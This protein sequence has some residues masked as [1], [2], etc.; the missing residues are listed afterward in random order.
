MQKK[1][2]E[3]KFN[4]AIGRWMLR[5]AGIIL[6]VNVLCRVA[7]AARSME[8][9]QVSGTVTKTQTTDELHAGKRS[10]TYHVWATYPI[11]GMDWSQYISEDYSFDMFSTGDNVSVLY[12]KDD[13]F[14]AY[15]AKK[16]WMTGAYLPVS[17]SYNIPL[18]ISIV[19]MVVGSL[20]Y[21]NS[22]VL[23]W[24]TCA[25]ELIIGKKRAVEK[26]EIWSY[27]QRGWITG[28]IAMIVEGV[29]VLLVFF[30]CLLNSLNGGDYLS[31][32]VLFVVS[33]SFLVPGILIVKWAKRC[34]KK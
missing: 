7:D 26:R 11:Q 29:M 32:F 30:G 21:T 28:G 27:K 9:V 34:G 16:D 17:K 31:L 18:A 25:G 33:M 15:I 10:Y 5:I 19:L 1:E 2:E 22:P 6:C 4:K 13:F 12:R 23:D 3:E 8:Y 20:F 24:Y 14:E